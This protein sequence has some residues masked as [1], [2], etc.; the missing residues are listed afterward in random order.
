MCMIFIKN[1]IIGLKLLRFEMLF[2]LSLHANF[3]NFHNLEELN[4]SSRLRTKDAESRL[5]QRPRKWKVTIQYQRH[6]GCVYQINTY[7]YSQCIVHVGD[8][9]LPL[10]QST[11]SAYRDFYYSPT[12]AITFYYFLLISC[13][14]NLSLFIG[15]TIA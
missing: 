2:Y 5:C 8:T 4:N 7:W 1:S 6:A 3:I 15:N 14:W 13:S 12:S 9:I 10:I 11:F